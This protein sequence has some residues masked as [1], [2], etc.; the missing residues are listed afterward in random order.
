MNVRQHFLPVACLSALVLF[1]LASCSAPTTAV[2]EPVEPPPTSTP[3]E[4]VEPPTPTLEPTLEP[5][6]GPSIIS[7]TGQSL[8]LL[9]Q[10]EFSADAA[11]GGAVDIAVDNEGNVYV[12]TQGAGAIK[13]FD[14]NGKFVTQ[15]G[16]FGSDPGKFNLATGIAA[17][18]QGNVYVCDFT[19]LRIQKF[20][21]AGQFIAE[22][23]TNPGGNPGSLDIDNQGHVFVSIFRTNDNNLQ[24]YADS[25]D[26]LTSWGGTGAEA[27][28]FSGRIEDIAVDK[29]GNVY[30]TD[31]NGFRVQKFDANGRFLFQIGSK[32]SRTGNGQFANPK[33]VTV[34]DD[35]NIYIVDDYFLQ[36]FDWQGNFLTQWPTS[37]GDLLDRAG[38]VT[39]DS[40]GNLYI[41][42]RAD[43]ISPTGASVN[44]YVVKKLQP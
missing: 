7:E 35:G 18:S 24:K 8:T 2:G 30:V 43:L 21:S 32:A 6:P 40:Q 14:A 12:T 39:T 11:L 27:G 38:F 37:Q 1:N 9:W 31:S 28:Q 25:G 19:N 15:W 3:G 4:P 34:D 17:D 29:D 23:P 13:K 16:S 44:T 33:G 10:S 26:Y 42:A 5:T 36:K 41:L 20:D 22:W